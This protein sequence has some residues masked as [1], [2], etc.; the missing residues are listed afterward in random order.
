MFAFSFDGFGIN[1]A[2]DPYRP[3]IATLTRVDSDPEHW[4]RQGQLM[5][6]APKLY[7]ALADAIRALEYAAPIVQ[8]PENC[9]FRDTIEHGRA[10]LALLEP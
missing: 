3:R 2:T 4:Q 9:A 1:D 8:A 6:A 7:A 5:A 10:L